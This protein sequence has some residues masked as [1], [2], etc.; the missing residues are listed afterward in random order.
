[1]SQSTRVPVSPT[2][3]SAPMRCAVYARVSTGSQEQDGTS[4]DTQEAS[5]RHHA[6]AKGYVVASV[7]RE[8]HTGADL[9]ERSQ[10]S[11]LREVVRRGEVDVVLAHALDRLTRN[12]AHLGVILSEAEYA[13]VA[14][15]LVTER[16]EDTPEGR[17]LQSVRGFVAEVERLK[18]TERT[19]RGIRARAESGKLLPGQ[20]ALYGYRWRDAKKTGYD[21]D[22][23]TAPIVRRIYDLALRGDPIRTIARTLTAEGIP[24]PTGRRPLWEPPT[25][26]HILRHPAYT[27]QG[28]AFRYRYPKT[29]RHGAGPSREFRPSDEQI[30]L[31]SG[32]VPPIVT[33]DEQAAV[34]ARLDANKTLAP[35]N[36][37]N[38]EANLL[39]SGIVR[40][41]YCGL[42][43]IV[44]RRAERS[45]RYRYNPRNADRH[46]CPGI[47]IE[48]PSLDQAVWH[49]VATVL[50]DPSIIASE[51]ERRRG[52]D[53]LAQDLAALDRRLAAIAK[54][55]QN[56][57]RAV[58]TLSGDDVS[59]PLLTELSALAAQRRALQVD[60]TVLATRHQTDRVERERMANLAAW[61]ERVG[62]NVATLS[63]AERRMVLEA[64][65]VSVKVYRADHNP[66][67]ELTMAPL[68]VV[69]STDASLTMGIAYTSAAG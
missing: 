2:S 47:K 57:A 46:G 65:G 6:A 17:L 44:E 28:I 51:V 56:L 18:I 50:N 37:P 16:L 43:M 55:R 49:R 52:A 32:T 59:A 13:G 22:P 3:I 26:H 60:R 42:T 35:R 69:D 9:F 64:L 12:Q 66:R 39:R 45:D 20:K 21:L 15:E 11:A 27:G 63:Y 40:C 34:A 24:T 38:P 14:V 41:G 36:N 1:M 33:A 4:L 54:Q 48:A 19:Q 31:P 68:P 29:K 8:V 5:C 30:L 53:S 7:Y 10:L 67:W 62:A 23:M 25:V 61:C 58:A